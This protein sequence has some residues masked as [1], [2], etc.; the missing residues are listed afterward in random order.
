LFILNDSATGFPICIM[1]C[2]WLTAKRFGAATALAAK[3]LARDLKVLGI[4]GCGV[5]GRSNLEALIEI[6][7]N[8]EEVKA[9]DI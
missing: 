5:Q 9:Y 2:R 1:D 3:Y 4:L 6:C 8:L 7:Q